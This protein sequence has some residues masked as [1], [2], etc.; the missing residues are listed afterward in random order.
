[1]KRLAPVLDILGSITGTRYRLWHR[2][3]PDLRSVTG[4]DPGWSLTARA[5]GPE[6]TPDGM[7]WVAQVPDQSDVW[8]EAI[9]T[10]HSPPAASV[11][12]LLPLLAMFLDAERESVRLV[13]ELATRYEE[14][15]LLYSIG[16]I[17]GETVDLHRA[18]SIIVKEV[19]KVVGADRASIMVHDTEAGLLR[20][21]ATKGFDLDPAREV[22]V[23]HP[24][25]IAAQVF[26]TMRPLVGNP[27]DR[28]ADRAADGRGYRGGGFLSVPICYA[29]SGA[30]ARC[31]GVI[32]LA[33]RVGGDGFTAGD[34]KLIEAAAN[35]IGTAIENA[36]LAAR[37]QEQYR[38]QH[39]LSLARELQLSLLPTPQALQQEAQVA[40]RCLSAEWVG[41]D[42]YTFAPLGEGR[43]GVMVGDV[44]SHGFSAA[45]VMALVLAAAGI[46][47]TATVP[48]DQALEGI[49]AS[50]A[51]KLSSTEMFC[52]IFYGVLDRRAGRLT[53]ANAGHPH[54]FRMPAD[55]PPERLE[56]VSAPLGLTS[57]EAIV[58][59]QVAWH[60]TSDLLCLWTDGLV[61][62]R[63]A[64]GERFGEARLLATLAAAR[65]E[66]P[67]R[68]VARVFDATDAFGGTASDDRTLLV[69]R[70]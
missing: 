30:Q 44:S 58:A 32:N 20:P 22:A 14:I 19:S 4:A 17:L 55:G 15:D 7:S 47:A 50:I 33:N 12:R 8:L 6:R 16:E 63:N 36:R 42:F 59:R 2:V 66:T 27:A 11:T 64:Q 3:G 41:G 65:E 25:S 46:H 70:V 38:L 60:A 48:P 31:V 37:E 1:M 68:I 18:A 9:G 28:P 57:G 54:A 26:R 62:T 51:E 23:D 34:Q 52:S 5:D 39:E 43:V 53:Y 69:L 61:D 29:G 10:E 49:R 35:Q 45:L 21:V 24:T 67:E 13:E 40:V 56:A